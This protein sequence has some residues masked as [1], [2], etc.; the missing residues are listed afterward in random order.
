MF[1]FVWW[2]LLFYK[3]LLRACYKASCF[4]YKRKHSKNFW[5]KLL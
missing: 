4:Y 5:Q 1:L 3:Y 2:V